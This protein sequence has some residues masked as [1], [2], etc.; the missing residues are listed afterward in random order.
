LFKDLGPDW[1]A[2]AD[3]YDVK[4]ETIAEQE[5]R[6]IDFAKLVTNAS[7]E[8]FA[9]RLPEFLDLEVFAAF[10]AGHVLLASYDGFLANGQNYYM[11]LDPRSNRFGFISWDQDHGWGDFG[12]VS[13]ADQ[14]EQASIWRPSL[15][16]NHFLNR[17][18]KVEAF[19]EVYRKKLETALASVFTVETLNAWVN[20]TAAIIRSA[21]AAESDLR[22]KRFD[23]AVSS[24]WLPGPRDGQG[25]GPKAPV[26]QIKRFI[27][28]RVKSVREQLD[29]K[30]EG[31]R[32]TG[33][34]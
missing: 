10:L 15:Y 12:Y 30:S 11:Y 21:V 20:E 1:N 28:N 32:L 16:E 25:E 9:A 31:V 29:G 6:V 17:V 27:E 13:S 26:H 24:E 3:I 7:D 19:R 14:R 34:R 8:E 23:Q 2:Y 18:L 22:L 5:R 33:W 4:T